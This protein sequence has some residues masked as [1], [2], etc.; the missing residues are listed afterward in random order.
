MNKQSY[1]EV[2]SCLPAGTRNIAFT[3]ISGAY[4][5][6]KVLL[7]E[8][9][10]VWESGRDGAFSALV[11]AFLGT[12]PEASPM[13]TGVYE[14]EGTSFYMEELFREKMLY[15]CGG[16]HVAGA[17]LRIA[18]MAGF[19][20]TILEDRPEYEEISKNAGA[21][22]VIIGS[23]EEITAQVPADGSSYIAI[24][25][26]G[27]R[28]DRECLAAVLGKPF[29]YIGMIGSRRKNQMLY[30]ALLEEGFTQEMIDAVHAPIGLS[31]HAETPVEIAVSI[32]AEIIAVKNGETKSEGFSRP[33]MKALTSGEP[34]VLATIAEKKGSAP[35][36]AGSKMVVYPDGHILG[37]V[38]GGRGEADI[39]KL[40]VR[41]LEEGGKFSV[42]HVDMTASGSVKDMDME[43]ICGGE[44]DVLLETVGKEDD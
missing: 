11:K 22:D 35:R 13:P 2:Q 38:G 21:D 1:Y 8:G 17:L 3:A 36:G 23:F 33:L 19:R 12:R 30:D 41:Q 9:R 10:T 27:H 31:I 28:H 20:V 16:G 42:H 44:V 43:L 34:V 25:T 24:M 26:K 7:T 32:L 29:A 18:K 15:I 6:E 39:I 5:G 40:A 37:T 14:Y 4:A